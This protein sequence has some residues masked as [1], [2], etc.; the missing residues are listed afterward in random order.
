MS[1]VFPFRLNLR[2]NFLAVFLVLLGCKA[3]YTQE[4]PVT[5]LLEVSGRVKIGT[6]QETIKRKRFYLFHG[7]LDANRT[8]IENLKA[9]DA[10]SRDC[11][12][13]QLHASPEYI[14]WLKA[15]DCESPYCRPITAEDM[16]QIPEFKAAYKKG[17]VQYGNKPAIAQKW[18]TTNCLLPKS[19]R[20]CVSTV[21]LR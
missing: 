6:K 4:S 15:G 14:A 17:L 8:L 18:L 16:T 21:Q 5:G 9:M 20:K 13:C 1:K 12:Y 3:A 11:F 7:G 19:N 2:L 10:P